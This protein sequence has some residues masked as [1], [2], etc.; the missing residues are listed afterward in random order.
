MSPPPPEEMISWVLEELAIVGAEGEPNFFCLK[1]RMLSSE[2]KRAGCWLLEDIWLSSLSGL[3]SLL[4]KKIFFGAAWAMFA[5]HLL[6]FCQAT[7]AVESQ[8][9]RDASSSAEGGGL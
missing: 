5:Q 7:S 3:G 4:Q 1:P 6:S 2:N 9:S 8:E